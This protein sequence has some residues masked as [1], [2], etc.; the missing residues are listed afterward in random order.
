MR[1]DEFFIR[2]LQVGMYKSKKWVISAF[3][4][5]REELNNEPN[6]I[7]WKIKAINGI[8]NVFLPEANDFTPILELDGS[9]IDSGSPI[10][11]F[12]EQIVVSGKDIINLNSPKINTTYGILLANYMLLV[13]PFGSKMDYINGEM[14]INKIEGMIGE[15]L[16]DDSSPEAK[17]PTKITV[18]EYKEFVKATGQLEGFAQL[19]VPT[20]TEKSL[21]THPQMKETI[22]RLKE[23][24]KGQLNDPLIISK[25]D[26]EVERL[27]REWLKG[28]PSERFYL[29]DKAFAVT[30]KKMYGIYGGEAGLGDGT[31]MDFIDRP[32]TDGLDTEKL[33]AMIN[34]LRSGSYDRGT[35]TALG[36]VAVKQF[37]RVFQ[38]SNIV[39]KDCGSKIG[40]IRPIRKDNWKRFLG[41]Y[42]IVNGNAFPINEDTVKALI[43]KTIEMR[44][45][46]TCK[47]SSTDYCE[48]CMGD[49]NSRSK[50]GLGAAASEIGSKF[51]IGF[52]KSMHG[53]SLK[54]E[55]FNILND[56]I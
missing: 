50:T 17:D 45:P 18:N 56:I 55:K 52:L 6:S 49:N 41:F 54:S 8:W 5:F 19:C 35:Q 53:R 37:F 33:P 31:T 25:I 9:T 2:A 3:S 32:L 24:Y 11:R 22:Q 15:R 4:V 43:G 29:K 48:T 28:D 20:V 27:D 42:H 34:S 44:S 26:A 12:N 16:V 1:K 39:E 51:M 10:Y 46:A 14:K 23:Q 21:T 36:G 13:Y 47:T 7:D 40:I 30:R 38:N